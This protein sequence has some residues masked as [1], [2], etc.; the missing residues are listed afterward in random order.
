MGTNP[1]SFPI[2][3]PANQKAIIQ[4][5]HLSESV[6]LELNN[7]TRVAKTPLDKTGPPLL[8][9]AQINPTELRVNVDKATAPFL[10]ILSEPYQPQWKAYYG[11]GTWLSYPFHESIPDRY[12]IIVNGFAN[13]WYV[14]KTGSFDITLYYV[15]QS[16]VYLGGTITVASG[17]ALAMITMINWSRRQRT[18]HRV[19][20]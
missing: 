15:P 2:S 4:V 5:N 11:S 19:E 6:Q 12:H 13:G 9:I 3:I 20:V 14:N 17:L 1:L 8:R 10:L 18:Y 7:V 16:L